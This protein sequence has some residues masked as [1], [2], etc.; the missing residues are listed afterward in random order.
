MK[1]FANESAIFDVRKHRYPLIMWVEKSKVIKNWAN[2][3]FAQM[4]GSRDPFVDSASSYYS[5]RRCY[6][7]IETTVALINTQK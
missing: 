5:N 7:L 4:L 2:I 1:A 6:G 3:L